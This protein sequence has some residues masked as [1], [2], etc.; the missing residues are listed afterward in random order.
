MYTSVAGSSSIEYTR[1]TS[2]IRVSIPASRAFS[3]LNLNLSDLFL[4][5][6]QL[7]ASEIWHG[8]DQLQP[9]LYERSAS[10]WHAQQ[11]HCFSAPHY[12]KRLGKIKVTIA[13]I[14]PEKREADFQIAQSKAFL[15]L[16]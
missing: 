13:G 2:R 15:G 3:F 1:E 7:L 9:N 5:Q 11:W 14:I 10:S 4:M 16:R 8:C 12:T 6:P